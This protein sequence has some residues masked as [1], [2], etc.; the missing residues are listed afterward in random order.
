RMN[1]PVEAGG[2]IELVGD[3]LFARRPRVTAVEVRGKRPKMRRSD[4]I[5]LDLC[6]A[7]SEEIPVVTR[8]QPDVG[9]YRNTSAIT[10][11]EA[12]L[13][14]E[15][16][17]ADPR[18]ASRLLERVRNL[19][20]GKLVDPRCIRV[21]SRREPIDGRRRQRF[22]L[23]V[24]ERNRRSD[25]QVV[26]HAVGEGKGGNVGLNLQE[27]LRGDDVTLEE[28]LKAAAG[29]GKILVLEHDLDVPV[30]KRKLVDSIEREVAEVQAEVEFPFSDRVG[31]LRV[32]RTETVGRAREGS[33]RR[34][35]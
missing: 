3:D 14:T 24:D 30:G 33:Q 5:P 10:R 34:I 26:R 17:I 21:P 8:R 19:A 22:D 20:V 12:V 18:R 31:A 1:R 29:R 28:G 16:D 15:D 9:S 7:G 11:R 27:I 13:G 25:V 32:D 4:Q 2:E 23:Y 6:R 35:V